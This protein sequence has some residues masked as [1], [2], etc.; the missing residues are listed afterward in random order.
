MENQNYEDSDYNQEQDRA[1]EKVIIDTSEQSST[2]RTEEYN[3]QWVN[4]KKRRDL[5]A[6][7]ESE[8]DLK[9]NRDFNKHKYKKLEKL[10]ETDM[11][12]LS[13]ASM[14]K[15]LP[16]LEQA[17]IKLQLSN[18]VLQAQIKMNQNQG[19]QRVQNSKS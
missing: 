1:N 15:T 6:S 3:K 11:F 17:Q 4:I 19:E 8:S 18:S 13:M 16:L 14:S 10:D 7:S 5:S 12:Y 2:P 9:D